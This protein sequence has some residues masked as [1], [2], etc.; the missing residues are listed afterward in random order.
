MAPERRQRIREAVPIFIPPTPPEIPDLVGDEGAQSIA[1]FQRG[2]NQRGIFINSRS[3]KDDQD[4]TNTNLD[5]Q[6]EEPL[7]V[8]SMEEI[9]AS[10]GT[11]TIPAAFY[12]VCDD[13]RNRYFCVRYTGFPNAGGPATTEIV[14]F[15]LG[16]GNFDLKVEVDPLTG[17][18][19]VY[20]TLIARI[21]ELFAEW[22]IAPNGAVSPNWSTGVVAHT[23][24]AAP[25]NVVPPVVLGY[26]Q[27]TNT[28]DWAIQNNG[29]FSVP[30]GMNLPVGQVE[31]LLDPASTIPSTVVLLPTDLNF[32]YL[33]GLTPVDTHIFA[34][35]VIPEIILTGQ[36]S[37]DLTHAN[38]L[39]LHV[40]FANRNMIAT[41][42][43]ATTV[44]TI[45]SVIPINVDALGL[46]TMDGSMERP[47]ITL[48][49]NQISQFSIF[50][51]T[52]Y[53]EPINLRG[54]GWNCSLR[55][56]IEEIP[57]LHVPTTTEQKLRELGFQLNR[58]GRLQPRVSLEWMMRDEDKIITD[59][60][61]QAYLM[62]FRKN[63]L[64]PRYADL[65]PHSGS[66]SLGGHSHEHAG[67]EEVDV[68][69]VAEDETA[70]RL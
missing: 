39:V 35:N 32:R 34:N 10:V 8:S 12:Q 17:T 14:R 21:E 45:L 1:G 20:S 4:P 68:R 33:V 57:P 54:H 22:F 19:T 6:L 67:G 40:S 56:T 58:E 49:G 11:L 38:E 59:E 43:Q 27:P 55:L 60:E 5:I 23:Q 28:L 52:S 25:P 61:A 9:K 70:D 31:L 41:N 65:K 48:P 26:A 30:A 42:R 63:A 44:S 62:E 66:A 36:F 50:L 29:T 47:E 13:F 3:Y 2:K 16:E 46:L 64:R 37:I 15:D 53:N 69:H 7:S 18:R 24:Y 51:T